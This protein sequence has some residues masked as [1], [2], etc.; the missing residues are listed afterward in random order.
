[1]F[2]FTS[3]PPPLPG[4][5]LRPD[6]MQGRIGVP[7]YSTS[8]RPFTSVLGVCDSLSSDVGLGSEHIGPRPEARGWVLSVMSP[9]ELR[10][11][12]DLL[13]INMLD[14]APA[15][16][17]RQGR[18]PLEGSAASVV[19]GI[20]AMGLSRHKPSPPITS[21]S[22]LIR[23]SLACSAQT[24]FPVPVGMEWRCR[25]AAN[26]GN[27]SRTGVQARRTRPIPCKLPRNREFRVERSSPVTVRTATQFANSAPEAD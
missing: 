27:A 22:L 6:P 18:D 4:R 10:S 16:A 23:T 3:P 11:L 12:E 13:K 21:G 9:A 2:E 5:G 26:R 1:M 15:Q 20:S 25:D 14:L 24:K 19:S 8:F 7:H 17:L